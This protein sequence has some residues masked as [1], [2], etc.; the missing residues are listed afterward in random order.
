MTDKRDPSHVLGD[1]MSCDSV[2]W[3]L[4]LMIQLPIYAI[5]DHEAEIIW[6]KL[7][8]DWEISAIIA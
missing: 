5:S 8:E 4:N 1:F 2:W 6:M 7:I 3:L